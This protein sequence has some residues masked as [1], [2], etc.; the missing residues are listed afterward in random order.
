MDAPTSLTS[1]SSSSSSSS[2]SSINRK[3][4]GSKSSRDN[5]RKSENDKNATDNV[6]Q[7]SLQLADPS[8]SEGI[9]E[10]N[11]AATGINESTN[12]ESTAVGEKVDEDEALKKEQEEKLKIEFEE[13][14]K[15]KQLE[16]ED[17]EID[18][19]NKKRLSGYY[20][21]DLIV[22]LA[23]VA[24]IIL[25]MVF[26]MMYG[27]NAVKFDQTIFSNSTTSLF[28]DVYL[29]SSAAVLPSLIWMALMYCA[30]TFFI[31]FALVFL[32]ALSVAAAAGLTI[33]FQAEGYQNYWWPAIVFGVFAL[34]VLIYIVLIQKNVKFA[35]ANLRVAV[36]AC[37]SK[38]GL[39]FGALITIIG[40]FIALVGIFYGT[41]AIA[42]QF[43]ITGAVSFFFLPIILNTTYALNMSINIFNQII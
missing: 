18:K 31:Q 41:Y 39:F 37:F 25:M 9:G 43:N 17:K 27:T 1:S 19:E 4:K 11:A 23:F 34:M 36:A 38:W 30:S 7:E 16:E 33:Q 14:K 6:K 35:S 8:G 5:D 42:Y 29:L 21:N 20:C 2:G 13:F 15:Q 3:N 24:Y 40:Q 22:A 28:L 12:T 32:L 26:A 10:D